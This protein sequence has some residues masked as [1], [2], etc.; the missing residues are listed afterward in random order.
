MSFSMNVQTNHVGL[1]SEDW[2]MLD[3]AWLTSLHLQKKKNVHMDTQQ[4]C[5]AKLLLPYTNHGQGVTQLHA[6]QVAS[7][8]MWSWNENRK[9]IEQPRLMRQKY[10][11]QI[12]S[13]LLQRSSESS[14]SSRS[15]SSTYRVLL[16]VG[17][18]SNKLFNPSKWIKKIL[19]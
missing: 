3:D 4:S 9:N 2:S 13:L 14:S 12:C 18:A 16:D 7:L 6:P 15:C 19:D 5:K 1:V 10:I 11:N 17:C 8:V